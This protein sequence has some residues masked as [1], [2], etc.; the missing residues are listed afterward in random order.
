MIGLW[1]RFYGWILG[2]VGVIVAVAG[3]YFRGRSAGK[4]VEQKKATQRD[5]SEAQ[6]HAETIRETVNVEA[7]VNRLPAD[8]VRE[9]LQKWTR[10]D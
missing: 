5:L 7:E 6:H 2:A 8:D 4:A 10:D 1:Q 9:R 3:V